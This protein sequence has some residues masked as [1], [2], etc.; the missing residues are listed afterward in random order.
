MQLFHRSFSRD[1]FTRYGIQV[2]LS[3]RWLHNSPIFCFRRYCLKTSCRPN[4]H[5][6]KCDLFLFSLTFKK[7]KHNIFFFT[8][9]C[10]HHKC[11]VRWIFIKWIH[12]CSHHSDLKT[13]K[14]A[15]PVFS[16]PAS[17]ITRLSKEKCCLHICLYRSVLPISDLAFFFFFFP[18][19]L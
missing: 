17:I 19:C 9:K 10:I 1:D 18:L 7:L 4:Y 3:G 11:T 8:L 16:K 13:E 14:K 2:I 5:S 15:L 12:V 6:F